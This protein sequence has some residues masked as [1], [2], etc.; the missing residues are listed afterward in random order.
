MEAIALHAGAIALLPD[1]L[2]SEL[3]PDYGAHTATLA[4]RMVLEAE[5]GQDD[6]LFPGFYAGQAVTG[7]WGQA[8]GEDLDFLFDQEESPVLSSWSNLVEGGW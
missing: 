5:E 3:A 8:G 7:L 2:R 1:S 6:L 4:W